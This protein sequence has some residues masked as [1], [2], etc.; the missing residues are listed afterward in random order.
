MLDGLKEA[1]RRVEERVWGL[2]HARALLSVA[3]HDRLLLLRRWG[4]WVRGRHH[5]GHV[6]LRAVVMWRLLGRLLLLLLLLLLLVRGPVV[7]DRVALHLVVLLVLVLR[8]HE[9]LAGDELMLGDAERRDARRRVNTQHW[10]GGRGRRLRSRRD[11]LWRLMRHA[12]VVHRVVVVREGG[13]HFGLSLSLLSFSLFFSSCVP[14]PSLSPSFFLSRVS[15]VSAL[16]P[17][18]LCRVALCRASS[19][20]TE[21]KARRFRKTDQRED[22]RQSQTLDEWWDGRCD[23]VIEWLID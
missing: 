3:G 7:C 5:V 6:A 12:D 11:R 9:L 17:S 22:T 16:L 14:R 19:N 8:H 20:K 4:E 2:D 21:T 23:G 10:M 13:M 15:F 1:G 18:C